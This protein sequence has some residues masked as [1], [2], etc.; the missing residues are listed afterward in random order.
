MCAA[1]IA[2]ESLGNDLSVK[3]QVTISLTNP[4]SIQT[5][6]SKSQAHLEV[7]HREPTSSV[8]NRPSLN[9]PVLDTLDFPMPFLLFC[10]LLKSLVCWHSP[11]ARKGMPLSLEWPPLKGCQSCVAVFLMVVRMF[12][13]ASALGRLLSLFP[14]HPESWQENGFLSSPPLP[15]THPHPSLF[16][17]VSM[18]GV[19]TCTALHWFDWFVLL[20]RPTP[21]RSDDL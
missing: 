3:Y 2:S 7:C 15:P 8:A 19:A 20:R 21:L 1:V 16:I 17:K 12:Q 6:G 4:T 9:C 11:Q 18:D 14:S 5:S 10:Q 13:L